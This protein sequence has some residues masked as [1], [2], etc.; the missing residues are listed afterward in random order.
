[1]TLKSGLE[2]LDVTENAVI[3]KLSCAFCSNYGRICSRLWYI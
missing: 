1:M 2:L 3:Q